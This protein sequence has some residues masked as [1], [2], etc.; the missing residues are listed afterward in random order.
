MSL[1]MPKTCLTETFMSGRPVISSVATVID[2]PWSRNARDPKFG[3][4]NAARKAGATLSETARAAKPPCHNPIHMKFQELDCNWAAHKA[5]M[6]SPGPMRNQPFSGSLAEAH[7]LEILVG[8][9]DLP[10]PLFRRA[11]AA[12]GIRVVAFHQHLEP[13]LDIGRG[14]AGV[15]PEGIERTPLGVA[16]DTGLTLA[17]AVAAGTVRGRA[18]VPK[19]VERVVGALQIRLE[20]C[21]IG[22]AGR[23]AA[24]HAHFPG[25]TMADHRL[26][27]VAGDVVVAHSCKEIVRMVVFAHMA[28]AEAPVLILAIA[29]LGSAVG[30]SPA[31]ARPFT[32]RMLGAQ[33]AILV[34]LDPNAVEQGRVAGHRR[35]I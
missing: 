12:I 16:D 35:I 8:L 10:Q 28:E 21:R 31:A 33:P 19:Q 7:R 34:R 26:L 15:E 4:S 23:A 1:S 3:S 22:A 5:A 20:P 14:R 25:G 18:K 2:P 6:P 9:N 27:L 11:V 30:R 24:V 17:Q 29:A 32:A 13:Q